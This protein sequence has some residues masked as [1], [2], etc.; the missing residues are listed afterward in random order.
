MSA[1]LTIANRDFKSFFGTPMGWIAACILFLISGIV[2]Y[3]IVNILLIRGQSI[4]PAG[5]IFGQILS[6]MNYLNIF[7]V[8][9]FTMRAMSEE[10]SHGT[11][12]LLASAPISSWSIVF[13]KFFGIVFYF[14]VIGLLL[15]IYPLYTVIFT[16]PDVKVMFAGWFG[17]LL[18]SAAIISIGLFMGSLTK[19]PVLSYLGSSFFILLFVFSAF[20]TGMPDWYKNNVNLLA[21][22]SDFT[23]G[24]IKTGSI[25]TY[26][27]II[28][29]FLTLARFVLK[30]KKWRI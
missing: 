22:S 12:R 4:D 1:A 30:C 2:F 5:D 24:V 29:V 21:L 7:I 15:L 23:R 26:L 10:F 27:A 8:P 18:N 28:T 16:T 25:A 11:Y 20:I 19:S 9:A 13:G 14:A 6:F 17:L 3:I